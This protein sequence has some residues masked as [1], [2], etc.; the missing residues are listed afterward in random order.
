MVQERE[1]EIAGGSL[2]YEP[3]GEKGLCI[4]G[5]RG[6][7]G[8]VEIPEQI[9]GIPVTAIGRK[10]FL[11]KKHLRKVTVPACVSEVGDWAFAYCDNLREVVFLAP[12][13]QE[14]FKSALRFGKAV[15]LECGS[16]QFIY[17]QKE[18][19]ATAALMA[20]AVTTADAPYLLD[21]AEAGEKEWLEKW[22]ARLLAILGSADDEGYS[23]QV[24]CGEEDYG[25]T[26]LAAY[27]N[28]QRK[29][30]VRLLF[31]RR[32]YDKGLNPQLCR[33]MEDYLLTHTKGCEHEETW[34]VVL[35]EHGD[36]RAYYELFAELGCVTAENFEDLLLEVGEDYP[37]LRAYL[38]RYKEARLGYRDFFA[39]LDL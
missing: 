16:L 6:L 39:G 8:E 22:D 5:F 14:T 12:Q 23:R 33:R 26:D 4:I 38:M 32:M 9:E 18:D 34:Q 11:S 15:F 36:D 10:A 2:Y 20:A 31:L 25:S 13:Q 28:A 17:V 35:Q 30:K 7:A 24:L 1:Y 37:E 29:R 21:A 3:F 27:E 19:A